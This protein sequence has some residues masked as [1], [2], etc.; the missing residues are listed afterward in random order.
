VFVI[1]LMTVT[2]GHIFI[3]VCNSYNSID[4]WDRL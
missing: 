1:I 4:F 2:A 3:K